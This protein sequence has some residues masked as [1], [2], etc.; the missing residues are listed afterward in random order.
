MITPF[1]FNGADLGNRRH[2]LISTLLLTD[3]EPR[4]GSWIWAIDQAVEDRLDL[5]L[6]RPTGRV[7]VEHRTAVGEEPL[8]HCDPAWSNAIRIAEQVGQEE[9][10]IAS[11]KDWFANDWDCNGEGG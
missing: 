9:K 11:L 3:R 5:K 4:L 2:R 7:G 6:D 1:V 8:D 10:G